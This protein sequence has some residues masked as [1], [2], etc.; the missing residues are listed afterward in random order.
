MRKKLILIGI[1]ATLIIAG[2]LLWLDAT[3]WSIHRY[4][5]KSYVVQNEQLPTCLSRGQD[6]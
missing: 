2:Y 1:L 6:G 3:V 5:V 4:P